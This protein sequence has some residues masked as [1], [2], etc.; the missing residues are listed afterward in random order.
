MQRRQRCTVLC[1]VLKP[2]TIHLSIDEI[3]GIRPG[4]SFLKKGTKM[5][6]LLAGSKIIH[7][8]YGAIKY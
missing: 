3:E 1:Y 7:G 2:S 6:V 4:L 5:S 8:W